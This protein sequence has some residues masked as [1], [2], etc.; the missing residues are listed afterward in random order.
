MPQEILALIDKPWLLIAVLAAGAVLGMGIERSVETSRRAE[1]R[2]YWQKRKSRKKQ[3]PTRGNVLAF[4]RR[5]EQPAAKGRE[6]VAADQLR[7]VMSARFTACALLNVPERR[8]L[9]VLENCLAEQAPGWRCMAQVNLGEILRSADKDA[10]FAI[11]SKRVDLLIVDGEYKPL[12][13]VEFQGTGHHLGAETAARDATK[14]EAL[15]RAGIGYVEV[16]SGDT[17]ADVR[18]IVTKL[19]RQAGE[20]ASA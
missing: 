13:A 8:L 6:D 15:R 14:R 19:V 7:A 2:A 10:Y 17:P 4:K 1:R 5:A 3:L 9:G 11:N 12:H 18:A 16:A 20:T